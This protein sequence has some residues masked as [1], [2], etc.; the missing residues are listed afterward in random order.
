[1]NQIHPEA[2]KRAQEL[3]QLAAGGVTETAS[4]SVPVFG[5]YAPDIPIAGT[6]GPEDIRGPIVGSQTDRFGR[7][8]ELHYADSERMIVLA[9][10]AFANFQKAVRVLHQQKAINTSASEGTISKLAF[11]WLCAAR[12]RGESTETVTEYVEAKL[13]E[14]VQDVTV[15][16]PVFGLHVEGELAI[17]QVIF[18]DIT[19]EEAT[20]WR[21]MQQRTAPEHID[22]INDMHGKLESKVLGR[23][24]ARVRVRAEPDYAVDWATEQA[25][26]S[27]GILRLASIGA[28]APEMPTTF[29]LAGREIVMRGQDI[30]VGP[31]DK[32]TT[33]EYIVHSQEM[34]P[35]VFDAAHQR[36]SVIPITGHWGALLNKNALTELETKALRSVIIYS[37]A[38]RYRNISEKLIHVFAAIESVFLRNDNEP[39]STA[40]S[41]RLAFA[42]GA[43]A[44][45]RLAIA[46][47]VKEVYGIRSKFVHHAVEAH[48]DGP[49]LQQ[50]E[51]FLAVVATFYQNM[52]GF[53]A[54][55]AT[56]DE[57]LD[58]LERRKYS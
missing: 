41:E 23:C 18:K 24:A 54:S 27:L 10:E 6:F 45:T 57:F 31:G 32:F 28:F 43:D 50:L 2:A 22:A 38:T 53:M 14:L 51:R 44:D 11:E 1:M 5:S 26:L 37:R 7:D 15:I 8:V 21:A 9:G 39:I 16:L 36:S 3:I 58:A 12:I 42:V 20:E 55:F 52:K 19:R 34:R 47:L 30:I 4:E 35:A 29:A 17:G 25:E 40:I 48:P 13:D 56:P 46:K 49:V 33:R